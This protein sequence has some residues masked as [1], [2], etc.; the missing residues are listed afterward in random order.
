MSFHYKRR[1]LA[2]LTGN[3]QATS[4][5]LVH[6]NLKDLADQDMT[7][8]RVKGL[9]D[10]YCSYKGSKGGFGVFKAFEGSLYECTRQSGGP[11]SHAG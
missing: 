3:W 11:G 4:Y 8:D 10:V 9:E 7:G 1:G 5:S 2:Y 6:V